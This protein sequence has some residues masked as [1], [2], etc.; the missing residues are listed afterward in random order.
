MYPLFTRSSDRQPKRVSTRLRKHPRRRHSVFS[1]GML[2]LASLA[3]TASSAVAVAP[4]QGFG[5]VAHWAFDEDYASSVNNEFYRGEAR[6][7]PLVS[8]DRAAGA[9]AVG[10][11]ALRIV[12]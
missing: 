2:V 3:A 12:S 11:G 9:A 10:A 7:G 1:C 8:I 6:G 5:L 4:T